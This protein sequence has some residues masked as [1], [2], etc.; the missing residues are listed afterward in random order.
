M[1]LITVNCTGLSPIAPDPGKVEQPLINGVVSKN[2][3]TNFINQLK[4]AGI[5]LD[6][7]EF[8]LISLY[9]EIRP[10]G[11][12]ASADSSDPKSNLTGNFH[13]FKNSFSP[14]GPETEFEYLNRAL[15]FANSTNLYARYYFDTAYYKSRK[16][17][18]VIKW[19]T[20][21][22]EFILVH[23]DGKI[24]NYQLTEN[25]ALPRYIQVPEN[26]YKE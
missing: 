6:N 9:K 11:K 12:W 23:T 18:L 25:I 1:S 7:E 15:Q 24:S 26:F 3:N 17:I 21:T 20:Q 19:D 14:N 2:P 22:K 4:T 13:D 16:K 5:T 10:N 8:A